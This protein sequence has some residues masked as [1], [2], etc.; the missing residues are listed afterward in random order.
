M[1]PFSLQTIDHVVI[2]AVNA[3]ELVA[4]YVDAIG[5][6]LAWDRPELGLTH[7]E[8]GDAMVDIISIDGPLGTKGVSL[9]A[10][11]GR[12]VD[13]LCLRIAPF[14]YDALRAHFEAFGIAIAPAQ[15]RYGAQGQGL[16]I[17]LT[18]PEGN[19]IEFKESN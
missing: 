14:D 9:A 2:R 6:K 5:C 1:P 15:T 7:L 18:D 11:P 8:A 10:G 4:F 17:Y 12:N 19:G 3:A 13:H 16:S